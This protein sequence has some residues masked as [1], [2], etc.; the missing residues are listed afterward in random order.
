MTDLERR[1][2]ADDVAGLAGVSRWTVNR[3]FKKDA[4]ISSKTR[5][6]VL[7]AAEQIGYVPDLM[8]SSLA[9]DQSHLVAIL[10]DD[11]RNSHKLMFLEELTQT[12]QQNGWDSLLVNTQAVNDA[13]LT[14]R[15]RRV[16]AAVLIGIS[17]DD[18]AI[19]AAQHSSRLKK[20]IMFGRAS[21]DPNT[22]SICG[23]VHAAMRDISDHVI[24]Q[25]Y[26]RP[27]YLAGPPTQSSYLL[28]KD[29]FLHNWHEVHSYV[30]GSSHVASYDSQLAY[31][32][33]IT[34]LAPLT[35]DER[36]DII[37]CE[38]DAIAMGAMDAI[39]FHFGLSVPNDI[40]V[41]GYDDVP[42]AASRAYRLTTYRQ[43]I[44]AMAQGL[45]RVLNGEADTLD[46]VRFPG[47]LIIRK[48]A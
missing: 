27:Y 32:K 47:Q 6:K 25:G 21:D 14:A 42:H 39:R 5:E 1:L 2:T 40:A 15:Q 17:I 43:P 20:M 41:I 36:P 4:S 48:S 28:R 13:F 23:D 44:E 7:S 38:N 22:I 12:L 31:E 34:V 26:K 35:T 3:A 8:A 37:V 18:D 10:T 11:F 29:L 46:L 16:D 33:M 24:T 45:L 30:P 19:T 9:S